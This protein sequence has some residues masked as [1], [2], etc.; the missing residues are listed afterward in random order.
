V[1]E[2]SIRTEATFTNNANYG[3]SANRES[4]LILEFAPTWRFN[5]QGG[6]LRVDGSVSLDMI[7]YVNGTQ[8]SSILPS[9]NILANL[10]AIDNLFYV[11]AALVVG[12]SIENPFLP[13][14]AG[15]STNNLYTTTQ[16]RLAPYLQGTVG[17]YIRWQV[18]S[19]NTYNWTSQSDAPLENAYYGRHLAEVVREPTPFGLTLRVTNDIT[20]IQNQL[21]PDQALYTALAIFD[22]AFTPQFKFGLRGGY[23]STNYTA[24]E[25]SGPIYGANL[26]WRPS[27]LTSLDGYWEN[28]FYGPSYQY[29]FSH[30]Q[31]RVASSFGGYRT[32]STYPQVLFQIPSTSS[33]SGLLDAILVAR[34]PDPVERAKQAQDLI[35]RQALPES[36]PAG[37]YIYNASANILTGF[38]AGWALIGV[39]NTLALNLFYLK[40]E[41]LP[42]ARI[43]PSF[44]A[45][46]NSIQR[47]GAV[48]LSHL[49]TPVLT[50]NGTVSTQYTTGFDQNAG[51]SGRE[52]WVSLQGNWQAAPRSTLFFGARYQQQSDTSAAL[53]F[54][55]SSETTVFVGLFHRL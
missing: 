8:V 39:R 25:T 15:P 50:L 49:M 24:E 38:N 40:T 17:P 33:V 30:R 3:A 6:R 51:L 11:D 12:Q 48:S 42:D 14:S 16:V 26:S 21:Q 43:P 4:D 55:E 53:A 10:E 47:G 41:Y 9:A 2:T 45:F 22:Y 23:E 46:N 5:R 36:L 27:P 18:R 37:T 1:T 28:R 34:F 35:T 29:Q 54:T 20:R 31:R 13:T 52:S 32:I 19:D 7:G 44:L